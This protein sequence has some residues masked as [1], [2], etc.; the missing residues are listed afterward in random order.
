MER[1][2]IPYSN[3]TKTNA[4]I[5]GLGISNFLGF[6][7][8]SFLKVNTAFTETAKVFSH[9]KMSLVIY[10]NLELPLKYIER[11]KLS[12]IY[13]IMVVYGKLVGHINELKA[14]LK[15]T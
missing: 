15:T 7:K 12:A 10:K 1:P 2:L 14:S 6:P 13:L 11:N 9:I 5:A 4:K 3:C 8:N